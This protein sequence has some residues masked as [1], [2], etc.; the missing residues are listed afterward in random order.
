M[1]CYHCKKNCSAENYFHCENLKTD[2][3]CDNIICHSC[4]KN[5]QINEFSDKNKYYCDEC[6][7]EFLKN[8]D[9]QLEPSSPPNNNDDYYDECDHNNPMKL[10]YVHSYSKKSS[11]YVTFECPLCFRFFIFDKV[12]DKDFININ[13][14]FFDWKDAQNF[15]EMKKVKRKWLK[16]IRDATKKANEKWQTFILNRYE[17]RKLNKL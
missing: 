15:D 13:N 3:K 1:N 9:E 17:K 2:Y 7:L 5:N 16:L 6:L 10:Y 14:E 12:R 8:P 11:K 4:F